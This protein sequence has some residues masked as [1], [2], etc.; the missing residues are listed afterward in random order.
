MRLSR[1]I[2]NLMRRER[3]ANPTVEMRLAQSKAESPAQRQVREQ[4]EALWLEYKSKGA[5][6]AACGQAVKTKWVPQFKNK[7]RE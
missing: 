6:W 2:R 1:K 5:T 4:V 7:Y 3:R